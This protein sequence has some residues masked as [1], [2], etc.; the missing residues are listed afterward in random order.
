MMLTWLEHQPG[1]SKGKTEEV[2]NE[3]EE[4]KEKERDACQSEW[5][6]EEQ[7]VMEVSSER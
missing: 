5:S 4:E 6:H 2:E 1:K 3:K 7:K